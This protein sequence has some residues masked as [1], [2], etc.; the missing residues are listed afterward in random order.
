MHHIHNL[1]QFILLLIYVIDLRLG[2]LTGIS[3]QIGKN[4]H[5]MILD[6]FKS[7]IRNN[8]RFNVVTTVSGDADKINSTPSAF[9]LILYAY[10]FFQ[11]FLFYFNRLVGQGSSSGML[12][13]QGV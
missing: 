3:L 10:G 5:E 8:K 12:S 1:M 11:D 9:D 6:L 13:I 4:E 2:Y 7:S